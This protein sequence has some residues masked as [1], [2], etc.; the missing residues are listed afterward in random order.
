[1]FHLSVE[2]PER[3]NR[4]DA[5]ERTCGKMTRG[6]T[7]EPTNATHISAEIRNSHGLRARACY[8]EAGIDAYIHIQTFTNTFS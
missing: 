2:L 5:P 3:H 4:L 6:A 1:M 7:T 8:N